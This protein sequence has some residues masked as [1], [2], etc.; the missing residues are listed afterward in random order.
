MVDTVADRSLG[1]ILEA[2]TTYCSPVGIYENEGCVGVHEMIRS[3]RS[4]NDWLCFRTQFSSIV[5]M[6]KR[7]KK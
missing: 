1:M 7:E 4:T 2:F 3:N 6:G 5:L